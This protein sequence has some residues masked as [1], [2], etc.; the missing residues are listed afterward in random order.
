[1]SPCCRE[2]SPCRPCCQWRSTPTAALPASREDARRRIH[3]APPAWAIAG[4]PL[5]IRFLL[6]VVSPRLMI[7]CR[8]FWC[9]SD[10]RL[11][12][13]WGDYSDATKD[14]WVFINVTPALDPG[15]PERNNWDYFLGLLERFF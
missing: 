1:M 4:S 2:P 3:P 9:V 5:K 14:S 13:I 11:G 7:H 6:C 12:N 10:L 15:S 8:N